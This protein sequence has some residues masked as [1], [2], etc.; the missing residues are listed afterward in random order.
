MAR[1][2][3]EELLDFLK[4]NEGAELEK[5]IEGAGYTASRGGRRTLQKS[6]FFAA[7]SQANGY[8]LGSFTV[9]MPEGLGKEAS[10]RLKVGPKGLIPVSRAY[11]DQIGLKPGDYVN[12]EIDGDA[13]LLV[14]E[15]KTETDTVPFDS[16]TC[17]VAIA[18]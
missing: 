16:S 18:A 7:F 6:K 8:N 10:Y 3:G 12:V 17:P 2:Q 15:D 4:A 1:L 13:I 11:T 14:R 9:N 5:L